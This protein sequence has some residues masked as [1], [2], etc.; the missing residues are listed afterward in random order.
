MVRRFDDYDL[1]GHNTFRMRVKCACYIE[2]DTQWDLEEIDFDSLPR[3]L[4]HIGAGSNML[5]TGDFPGTVLHSAVKFFRVESSGEETVQVEVGSGIV[6]DDFCSWACDKG[7]WGMENLSGIPGEVGAAAV[8][9][10]GAY[11]VEIKD[12]VSCVKCYDI[13][14]RRTEMLRVSD[15]A[16]GYR[17]SA[18][19]HSPLKGR[20]I[21]LSVMFRLSR[22]YRPNLAYGNLA[23]LFEPGSELTPIQVRQAVLSVRAGKLPDPAELG[24]AGSFFKNP[25]VSEAEYARVCAI[26][27][28]EDGI[29]DV[30]HYALADGSV[31]I[32]AAWL[33]D[34]CGYRGVEEGG[35]AVYER[36][37]LVIVNR[38]GNA[39]PS[40][41]LALEERIIDGVYAK[42]GIRLSPEVEHI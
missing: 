41:I 10:V 42:Y 13:T 1:S 36:Q 16:Y 22:L 37:P 6:L 2:Y 23:R 30:P 5:F 33:I 29:A 21:V 17:D 25:V 31:K 26:A 35:A 3:P 7:L 15:C 20:Y 39:E 24:S 9:N 28:E 4:L 12:V 18:F 34:N 32:P 38:S 27:A 14:G 8:Q 40:D 11:G 19:K